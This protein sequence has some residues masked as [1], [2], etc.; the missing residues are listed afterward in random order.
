MIGLDF[1]ERM[2]IGKIDLRKIFTENRISIKSC[3]KNP[4]AAE[5][6]KR[7]ARYTVVADEYDKICVSG[8]LMELFAVLQKKETAVRENSVDNEHVRFFR[9]IEPAVV[10]IRDNYFRKLS[11]DEL[12]DMCKMSKYHFC[13]VFKKVMGITPVQYQTECRL[14]IADILLKNPDL[15][16]TEIAVQT[17]YDDEAY[18]SR[19]YKKHR[20]VAPKSMRAK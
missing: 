6:M 1:F 3:I 10:A 12:A 15:S 13:R 4:E 20:G 5:I 18:F 8:L 14:R 7:L 2:G 9:S 17:G 19:C 16:I 11:G